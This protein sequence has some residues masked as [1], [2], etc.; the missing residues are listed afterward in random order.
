L[1]RLPGAVGLGSSMARRACVADDS[2]VPVINVAGDFSKWQQIAP[3]RRTD[4]TSAMHAH[5]HHSIE[6]FMK[7]Q[8]ARHTRVAL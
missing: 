6:A 8:P 4:V 3:T 2:K 7:Q 1:F 5:T